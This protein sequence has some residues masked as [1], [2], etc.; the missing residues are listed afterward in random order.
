MEEKEDNQNSKKRRRKGQPKSLQGCR[1][2]EE[3]NS[4]LLG[5][6]HEKKIFICLA[7]SVLGLTLQNCRKIKTS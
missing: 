1:L 3:E 2:E 5:S 7:S 6:E 4:I